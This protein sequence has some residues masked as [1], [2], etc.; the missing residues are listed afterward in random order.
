MSSKGDRAAD[1]NLRCAAP[2]RYRPVPSIAHRLALVAAGEAAA[3][4]S[5]HS[6]GAWDYGAG[7]ALLRGAGAILVDESGEASPTRPT[8]RAMRSVR[9][10][11]PPRRA[12]D[13][14]ASLG[15]DALG[16]GVRRGRRARPA[17]TGQ[18]RGRRRPAVARAGLPAGAGRRRQPRESRRV[19]EAAR[20]A[21][22]YPDGPRELQDGGGWRTLAGQPTDDSEM[23]L[24]LARAIVAEGRYAAESALDAYRRWYRS[25]PFDIGHT[26]RAALNGYLMGESEANGSL[27]RVSPLGIFAHA[28]P[29][30]AAAELARQDSTLTHP[31]RVPVDATA[32]F[33]VAI[34]HAVRQGDG[35][36]AA[37]SSAL[38]WA[39]G[40][41]AAPSVTEALER[42]KTEAPVCDQQNQGWVLIALQN[43]F[44]A[45][46]HSA[47]VEEGVVTTVRRG[48]DTD[49][50]AAIAGALLGAVHGRDAVPPQWRSMV[51][52]CRPHSLCAPRPRPMDYWPGDVLELAERLLLAGSGA[53]T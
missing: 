41:E 49:T 53:A 27:M 4:T 7:H 26:T 34:S 2:A 20:I 16:P 1:E 14:G 22:A 13:G 25:E 39:R 19:P 31:N 52:S 10:V 28:L 33:V 18:G 43:A 37:W 3:A 5:V 51:L 17:D 21:E 35:A 44:Y 38:A 36:E 47:S 42:A 29:A 50:N 8:D 23:A 46:L 32:A 12:R 15:V 40:A 24:A 9:S 30:D 48:G 45:A 11:V 6:P